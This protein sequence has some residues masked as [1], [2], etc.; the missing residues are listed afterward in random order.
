MAEQEISDQGFIAWL[1]EEL[2]KRRWTKAKLAEASG[3]SGQ[4]VS[5]ILL[6]QSKPG[7]RFAEGV[8]K[9]FDMSVLEVATRAGLLP[10]HG[11]VLPVLYDWNPR[12]LA[13]QPGQREVVIRAMNEVLRGFE[14]AL[15]Q[16]L[17]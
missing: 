6:G 15:R 2:D 9:A 5:V 11:E 16:A 12:L 1:Q 7:L 17:G 8:A 10:E 14:A 4:Q 13:M 3:I